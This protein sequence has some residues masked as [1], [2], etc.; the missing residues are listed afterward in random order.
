MVENMSH[1]I[2]WSKICPILLLVE[3]M[4]TLFSGRKTFVENMSIEKMSRCPKLGLPV[5][6]KYI[7]VDLIPLK[8]VIQNRT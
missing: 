7:S 8:S 6:I 3:N 4:S 1:F 2:K 5:M